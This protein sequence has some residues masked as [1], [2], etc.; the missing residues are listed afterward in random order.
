VTMPGSTVTVAGLAAVWLLA[1]F[2]CTAHAQERHHRGMAVSPT[3]S[4]RVFVPAGKVRI[5]VW[6]RDSIDVSGTV[7]STASIFGGGTREFAKFG[8]EPLR[9]GDTHLPEADWLVTV[10]VAAH[11]WVKMTA[12][13]IETDG[14]AGELELYAVGGSITV[15]RATGVTSVESI[16]AAVSISDSRGDIRLRGGK[17]PMLLQNVMGTASVTSVNGRVDIRGGVAPDGRIETIGGEIACNVLQLRGVVL[18]LQTHS[19]PIIVT[20]DRT[21]PPQLDLASRSGTVTNT[22]AKGARAQGLITARSFRGAITVRV[23]AN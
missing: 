18:E 16:D 21:A 1:A 5:A 13:I 12:G 9:T 6:R 2:P 22:A 3:V 20:V 14:T 4:M 15:R 11:V 8:V 23:R 17:A 10:P 19:G 7:G